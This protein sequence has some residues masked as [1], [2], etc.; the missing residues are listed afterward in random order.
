[1]YSHG[2]NP[3]AAFSAVMSEDARSHLVD[4]IEMMSNGP[5]RSM[6]QLAKAKGWSRQ[7]HF[8]IFFGTIQ[9]KSLFLFATKPI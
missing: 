1:V 7:T 3:P 9:T 2:D 6:A 8:I 4:V 5:H